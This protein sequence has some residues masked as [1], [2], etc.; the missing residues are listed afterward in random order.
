MDRWQAETDGWH[1]LFESQQSGACHFIIVRSR[2]SRD[3]CSQVMMP[4]KAD[5]PNAAM[6]P[7]FRSEHDGRGVGDLRRWAE[8]HPIA[9]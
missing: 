8:A 3:F 2:Q 4:N 5:A 9:I 6:T 7:Q 1:W